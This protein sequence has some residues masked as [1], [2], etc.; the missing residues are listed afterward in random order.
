MV[1]SDDDSANCSDTTK[2]LQN[3]FISTDPVWVGTQ[4]AYYFIALT[5]C[6]HQLKCIFAT[7]QSFFNIISLPQFSNRRSYFLSL[8]PRTP[9]DSDNIFHSYVPSRLPS[10]LLTSA[11]NPLQAGDPV[12][13]HSQPQLRLIQFITPNFLFPLVNTLYMSLAVGLFRG[14][15]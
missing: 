14:P 12:S 10:T 11:A 6:T 1:L 5:Y 7:L 15:D 8:K 13:S 2:S 9:Q 4:P 3:C